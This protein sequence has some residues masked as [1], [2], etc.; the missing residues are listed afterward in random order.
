MDEVQTSELRDLLLHKLPAA[1]ATELEN[2]VLLDSEFG[3]RLE[4]E[5]NDLLD[6]FSRGRLSAQ[7][8]NL[9]ETYL[10]ATP[11]AQRR[12]EFAKS[13]SQVTASSALHP[14]GFSGLLRT[15]VFSIGVAASVALLAL[16]T[17]SFW[18][19]PA[20]R[21][22]AHDQKQPAQT[23]SAPPSP[24]TQSP[25]SNNTAES[26]AIVLLN[27]NRRGTLQR[28]Y[29]IPPGVKLV[30]IQCEIPVMN[31]SSK[32]A[33]VIRDEAGNHLADLN[34]LVSHEASGV[35]YVEVAIPSN[36]MKSGRY[37]ATVYLDANRAASIAA[38]DFTVKLSRH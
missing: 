19:Q 22:V 9:V 33:V 17:F 37:S 8:T 27:E 6:D 16:A 20:Q 11:D 25:R 4:S 30:Q 7:D 18:W 15:P 36:Q 34:G 35:Q 32:F 38:Y 14:G 23:P 29:P 2:R 12:L 1:R 21:E 24:V 28:T 13:L 5:E 3:S 26:F 10:L 31:S